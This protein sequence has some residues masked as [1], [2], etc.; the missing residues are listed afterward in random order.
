MKTAQQWKSVGSLFWLGGH[1]DAHLRMSA[2]REALH[3]NFKRA[4][5]GI[6]LS[7]NACNAHDL[8]VPLPLAASAPLSWCSEK[9]REETLAWRPHQ[10]LVG[11]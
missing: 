11:V 4:L 2:S 1:V 10:R 3:R 5:Q 7:A 9:E 8:L 6:Y